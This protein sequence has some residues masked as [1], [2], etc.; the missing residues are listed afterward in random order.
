MSDTK[1]TNR[2]KVAAETLQILAEKKYLNS[3]GE[4][5]DLQEEIEY[6]VAYSK[7]YRPAD[8]ASLLADNSLKTT[9]KTHIEVTNETTLACAARLWWSGQRDI[10]ALNFAS[11]KNAGGGF[12]NGSQA[13]EE[14]IARSSAL[15]ATQMAHEGFYTTHRS[16]SSKLYTDNMIYSPK[17]P[18]FRNDENKLL[19]QPYLLSVITSPAVNKGALDKKDMPYI[20]TVSLVRIEKIIALAA[21]YKHPILILGAWGC[22]VFQNNPKDMAGYF[23]QKLVTEHIFASCFE[24]IIFGVYDNSKSQETLE[25]FREVF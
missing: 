8:F 6:A 19:D 3:K 9:H 16:L 21:H 5:I 18:V 2:Q 1:R 17:V 25:A 23:H 7:H 15:Y 12:I 24:K 13:Q 11:A 20:E 10:C 4:T 22:G 14:S